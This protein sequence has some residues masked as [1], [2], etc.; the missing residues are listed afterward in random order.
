MIVRFVGFMTMTG[1]TIYGTETRIMHVIAHLKI[2][3]AGVRV[4]NER[5]FVILIEMVPIEVVLH[6]VKMPL[7]LWDV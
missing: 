6:G 4:E 3:Q 5:D 7:N 1:I 2:F